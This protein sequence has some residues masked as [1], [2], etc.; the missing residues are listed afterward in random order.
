MLA[1]QPGTSWEV[2][3]SSS[4]S[5]RARGA[6]LSEKKAVARP[7][8]PARPVRPMRWTCNFFENFLGFFFVKVRERLH[9]RKSRENKKKFSRKNSQLT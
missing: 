2:S 4:A 8:F 9:R 6:S 5:P 1:S 3:V 7:F